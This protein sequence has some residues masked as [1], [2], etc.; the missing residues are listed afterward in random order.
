M[1]PGVYSIGSVP[2]GL[3][4]MRFVLTYDGPLPSNGDPR[5]KHAIRTHLHPQLKRQW[6]IDPYLARLNSGRDTPLILQ[7]FDPPIVVKIARGAFT[8]LPLVT[9]KYNLVCSLDITFMRPDEPGDLVKSGGDIDNRIKTL[10][11]SLCVPPADNQVAKCSPGADETPFYCL[12]ED[13]SLIT[14]FQ[15][16]TERLLAPQT[17]QAG[18]HPENNVRL[19]MTVVV[20]PTHITMENLGFVGGLPT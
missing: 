3:E 10:F 20:S 19:I 8:F 2:D 12:L 11:D 7:G 4:I 17:A 5:A 15:I 9:K 6:E 14:G 13:D 18:G 1:I 16:R